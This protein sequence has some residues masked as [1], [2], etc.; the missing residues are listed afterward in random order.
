MSDGSPE[1]ADAPGGTKSTPVPA[2]DTIGAETPDKKR[3]KSV[4]SN[5]WLIGLLT[6]L[7]SGVVVAFYLSATGQAALTAVRHRFTRP[8]CSDPQWLLQVPDSDVFA[9]AYYV[10]Y[11]KIQGYVTSHAPC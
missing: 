7:I 11:D 6:G 2:P 1:E 8:S 3:L 9:S 10:Q 4:L 5:S